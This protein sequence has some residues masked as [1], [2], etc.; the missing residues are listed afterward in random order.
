MENGARKWRQWLGKVPISQGILQGD[1]LSPLVFVMSMIPLT[2]ILCKIKPAYHLKIQCATSHLLHIDDL[3]LYGK[4]RNDLKTPIHTKF[5]LDKC[6]TI[7]IMHGKLTWR[8]N[9]MLSNEKEAH[10][11]E[12]GENYT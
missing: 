6:A 10:E 12:A 9:I 2:D 11:L 3:K 5:G 1:N 8:G 4:N 7:T